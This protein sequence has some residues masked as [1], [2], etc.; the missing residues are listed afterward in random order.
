MIFVD[1]KSK[2]VITKGRLDCVMS[3]AV[4]AIIKTAEDGGKSAKDDLRKLLTSD[5][6][7]DSIECDEDEEE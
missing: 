5:S 1:L 4:N 6:F 7:W 2:T 3:E